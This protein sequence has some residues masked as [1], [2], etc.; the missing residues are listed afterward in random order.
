MTIPERRAAVKANTL[1]MMHL[2]GM[3]TN[4]QK[5]ASSGQELVAADAIRAQ[6]GPLAD[7][8]INPYLAADPQLDSTDALSDDLAAQLPQAIQSF[9]P[10][11]AAAALGEGCYM[12]LLILG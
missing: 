1:A 4:S 5:R 7:A 9:F 2:S 12:C 3:L 11:S 8:V 6:F 10:G